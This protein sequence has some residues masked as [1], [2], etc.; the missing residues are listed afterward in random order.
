MALQTAGIMQLLTAEKR[1]AEKINEARKHK[2]HR[3]KQAK[4]AAQA[5]IEKYRQ[6]CAPFISYFLSQ[7]A[8]AR[9]PIQRI[10]ADLHGQKRGSRV[11]HKAQNRVRAAV[12]A[13]KRC[14]QQT[15]SH[16]PSYAVSLLSARQV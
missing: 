15:T 8:G 5:E 7:F 9:T 11:R 10:R 14:R 3:L 2:N 1:A 12:N 6:V 13:E 4:Q 16:R